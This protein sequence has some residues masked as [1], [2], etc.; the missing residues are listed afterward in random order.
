MQGSCLLTKVKAL[1]NGPSL[2]GGHLAESAGTPSQPLFRVTR[3]L[4]NV[5]E[6]GWP[7]KAH[8]DGPG[9]MTSAAPERSF[10][11]PGLSRAGQ[12]RTDGGARALRGAVSGSQGAAS[13]PPLLVAPRAPDGIS[14]GG[15][16][17]AAGTSLVTGASYL[18]PDT[19]VL[20][21]SELSFPR[22]LP[23]DPASP[24]PPAPHPCPSAGN[25]P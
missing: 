10:Q 3:S 18:L 22:L 7:T 25:C 5:A 17:A 1:P 4:E 23:P 16:K 14:H 24:G 12:G 2:A 13:S 21:D 9:A 11:D 6:G 19:D 20:R 8:L 15:P